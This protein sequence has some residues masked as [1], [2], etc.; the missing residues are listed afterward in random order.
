L[1]KQLNHISNLT[2]AFDDIS[3]LNLIDEK[4]KI[5]KWRKDWQLRFYIYCNPQDSLSS[6]LKRVSWC[7]NNKIL[8]YIMR[9]IKC[10]SSKFD[11]FYKDV[12]AYCNQPAYFKKQSF[13]EFL[14][15]RYKNPERI[16]SSLKIFN[17]I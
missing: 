7:K 9:D 2:F 1:I 6:L 4:I 10:W 14:N 17:H 11:H 15:A 5:L 12:S 13:E 8:P 3:L 16:I